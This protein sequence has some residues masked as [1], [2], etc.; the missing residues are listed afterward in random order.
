M[1]V[2]I[3][4]LLQGLLWAVWA[5]LYEN[6][7]SLLKPDNAKTASY[8]WAIVWDS[9]L[10]R[11]QSVKSLK[12]I[13]RWQSAV[14]LHWLLW[15]RPSR[16]VTPNSSLNPQSQKCKWLVQRAAD[17]GLYSFKN[18]PHHPWFAFDIQIQ[19]QTCIILLLKGCPMHMS[20]VSI[21]GF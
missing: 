11:D 13:L 2:Q 7:Q 17:S 5:S 12:C 18:F 21:L 15:E 19:L 4:L 16:W 10:G 14:S 20:Q 6:V 9:Y 1:S 3:I 8:L